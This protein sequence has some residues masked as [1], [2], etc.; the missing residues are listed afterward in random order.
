[1]TLTCHCGNGT[2]HTDQ[3]GSSRHGPANMK[4]VNT[5]LFLLINYINI[6]SFLHNGLNH[7]DDKIVQ[8]QKT[9]QIQDTH[10]VQKKIDRY[11]SANTDEVIFMLFG[12][13]RTNGPVNAHLTISQ[14]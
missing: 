10:P 12:N 13:Q 11:R 3:C 5:C 14:V 7:M 8:F 6:A 1:M 9:L 2:K 4:L